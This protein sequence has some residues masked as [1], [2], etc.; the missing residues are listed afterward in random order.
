LTEQPNP[1]DKG[2]NASVNA[3]GRGGPVS[4]GKQRRQRASTPR[5]QQLQRCLDISDDD[6]IKMFNV[7][8]IGV[9]NCYTHAARQMIKQGA[10]KDGEAS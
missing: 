3:N 10:V 1:P 2:V 5:C 9:W 4:L 6:V 7:N 8:F